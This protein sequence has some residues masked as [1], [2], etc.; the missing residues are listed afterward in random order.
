MKILL[1]GEGKTDI[2]DFAIEV[3]YRETPPRPGV[4]QILLERIAGKSHDIVDGVRW[5]K[6]RKLRSGAHRQRETRNVMGLAL[7]AKERQCDAIAFVRD[8]DGDEERQEHVE[9]GVS[10]ARTM[11]AWGGHGR[12]SHRGLGPCVAWANGLRVA[13]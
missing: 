7:M 12:G 5:D 6:L 11:L 2:G 1:G 3:P 8:R 13:H 9:A 10:A 4:V